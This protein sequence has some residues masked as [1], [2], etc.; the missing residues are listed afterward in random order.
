MSEEVQHNEPKDGIDI[1]T[2]VR[3]IVSH[4]KLFVL[5]VP[6]FV[7]LALWEERF[8]DRTYDAEAK[9]LLRDS[10]NKMQGAENLI[11]G[12][13]MFSAFANIEN[14]I[15]ILK[16]TAVIERTLENLDF[17]VSYFT[18]GRVRTIERY[19][20]FP[21]RVELDTSNVQITKKIFF[22]TPV[23]DEAY[24]IKVSAAGYKTYDFARGVASKKIQDTVR[25]EGKFYYGELVKTDY[26]SFR[27]IKQDEYYDAY[28]ETSLYFKIN[29]RQDQILKY[30]S[31]TKAK[32]LNKTA[33]IMVVGVTEMNREKAMNYVNAVCDAYVQHGLEDKNRMAEN[34]I[35]FIDRQLGWITDSLTHNEAELEKFRTTEKVMD[36]DFAS[37]KAFDNLE[38]FQKDKAALLTNERYYHYLLEYVTQTTV[39][40]T[41]VAPSLIGINDPLLNNLLGEINTLNKEKAGMMLHAGASNPSLQK[42]NS[43]LDKSR[44]TL[45]ENVNGLISSSEIK[46]GELEKS[47]G[48]TLAQVGRLPKNERDLINIERKFQL[49]DQLYKYLQEKRAEAAIALASNTADHKVLDYATLLGNGPSG[50]NGMMIYAMYIVLGI[51]LP[52][53]FVVVKGMIQDKITGENHLKRNVGLPY[54]GSIANNKSGENLP[55][56]LG[57]KTQVAESFRTVR[58]NLEYKISPD[59]KVIGVTSYIMG[60]GKSFVAANLATSFA[61]SGHSTVVIGGDLRKPALYTYI[62]KNN[63]LGLT[64]YLNGKAHVEDIILDTEHENLKMIA[65][66]PAS[67]F[68]AE[69]LGSQ[70][71]RGLISQLRDYFDYIIIDSPPIRVVAD[72]FVMS[73][74]IDVNLFIARNDFTKMK[75]V[76]ELNE[77]QKQSRLDNMFLIFNDFSEASVSFKRTYE[78]Y[79]EYTRRPRLIDW[80]LN[81]IR[82]WT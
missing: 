45:V 6:F 80:I 54:L 25:F 4:W 39:L 47:I 49:N 44:S 59:Q 29:D 2:T 19:R 69:M 51:A 50:P 13:Q 5:V 14:E 71:M 24:E 33:S 16:S 35:R 53:G 28:P 46:L 81:R 18:Q 56:L 9:L 63:N 75:Y 66:G 27:L 68:P 17:E 7:A 37:S 70:D 32:S 10:D 64:T 67:L 82:I 8:A 22:V 38:K 11:E 12:L 42:L 77:L 65:A 74:Y 3:R 76:K 43:K 55:L 34:T 73:D 58:S 72:Y 57:P 62:G 79:Y 40:D 23:S 20:K 60:E 31:K 48:K 61:M 21:F 36:I 1:G 15:G 41:L 52:L 78:G 30:K 26:F